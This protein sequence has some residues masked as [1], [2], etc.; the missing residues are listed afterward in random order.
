MAR[1]YILKVLALLELK[2]C[3]SSI[4]PFIKVLWYTKGFQLSLLTYLHLLLYSF[5]F[6]LLRDVQMSYLLKVSKCNLVLEFILSFQF[7]CDAFY[8][9]IKA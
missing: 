4:I 6:L 9:H 7:Q 1:R 8:L 2:L 3:H 5:I